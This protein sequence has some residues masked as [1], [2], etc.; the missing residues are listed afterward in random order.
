MIKWL[1]MCEPGATSASRAGKQMGHIRAGGATA[2]LLAVLAKNPK[3]YW[4]YAEIHRRLD[5][6]KSLN[7][8][9]RYARHM[10]WIMAT[11]DPRSE[12]YR[13]YCISTLGLRAFQ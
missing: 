11:T 13:R 2:Q 5:E 3:R 9:L 12:R 6:P 10:G 7:W 1:M 8:S 4:S